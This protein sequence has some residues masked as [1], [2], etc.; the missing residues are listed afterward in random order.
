MSPNLKD[1]LTITL[2]LVSLFTIIFSAVKIIN[3]NEREWVQREERLL[4]METDIQ[5][6]HGNTI[7]L[8]SVE[9]KLVDLIS[10]MSRIRDR[11][12]RFLDTQSS[13]RT[14]D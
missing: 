10:E 12:D 8:V 5:D 6:M 4:R 14:K 2:Q 11:L 9:A 13:S 3:K 1:W 7:K